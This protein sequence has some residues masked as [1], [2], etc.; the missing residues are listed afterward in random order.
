MARNKK[1]KRN[2]YKYKD[3]ININYLDLDNMFIERKIV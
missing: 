2:Q 3:I 1:L